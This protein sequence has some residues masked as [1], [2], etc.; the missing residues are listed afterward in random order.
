LLLFPKGLCALLCGALAD[1]KGFDADAA[2][3]ALLFD[4][5]PKGL[6]LVVEAA[7]K[8]LGETVLFPAAPKGLEVA[9][10][11]DPNGLAEA[12]LGA[13][14][15]AAA[16]K[17]LVVEFVVEAKGFG[18]WPSWLGCPNAVPCEPGCDGWPNAGAPVGACDPS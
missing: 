16:P 17:G 9:P 6:A 8:G 4:T 14:F 18:F 13:A 10:A 7:P 11:G 1:P 12:L 2:A 15:V 3:L 5:A